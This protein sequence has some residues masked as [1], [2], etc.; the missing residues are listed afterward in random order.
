MNRPFLA[1][2]V[3]TRGYLSRLKYTCRLSAFTQ[4]LQQ[5]CLGQLTSGSL[6]SSGVPVTEAHRI[7]FPSM[8][9]STSQ[10]IQNSLRWLITLEFRSAW[11]QACV[12]QNGT[13]LPYCIWF[14]HYFSARSYVWIYYHLSVMASCFESLSK[15]VLPHFT[16]FTTGRPEL[17]S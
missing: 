12:N 15:H 7:A 13:L 11:G 9:R 6:P 16:T 8:M 4:C 14:P 1:Y 3:F 2:A 5:S 17:K 10:M